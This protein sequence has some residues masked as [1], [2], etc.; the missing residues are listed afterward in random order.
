VAEAISVCCW[1]GDN[2]KSFG[3]EG[4][5]AA[6]VGFLRATSSSSSGP[7]DAAADVH[8]AT[9]RSLHELSRNPDNCITMHRAGAIKVRM[10]RRVASTVYSRHLFWRSC[11][12]NPP[13]LHFLPNGCQIVCSKSFFFGRGI[14]QIYHGNILLIDSKHRKLFVVEQE[15]RIHTASR[16]CKFIPEMRRHMFGG[17]PGPAGGA[18]ALPQT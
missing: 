15:Q 17:D 16:R 18:Y 12:G 10:G 13:N 14:I 9:A 1:Y 2:R 4:V 8:R 3:K 7:G 6:I 5:I 11:R